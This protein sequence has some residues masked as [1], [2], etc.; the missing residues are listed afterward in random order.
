[1]RLKALAG[2]LGLGLFAAIT[3]RLFVW[4]ATDPPRRADA[5]LVFA[6]G[7]GERLREGTRR[8][9][10]G[11]APVLVV[12]DGGVPG[13]RFARAC[14]QQL[15]IRVVCVTPRESSTRAEARVFAELAEREG[16]RSV[17]MVTSSY[18]VRRASL[19]LGRCYR[20]K[21]FTVAARPPR[22]GVDLAGRAL[23]E[24]AGLAAALTVQRGC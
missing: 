16:W 22:T 7:R 9:Q 3:A 21:V 5:V 18:H 8:V 4:P 13:S 24:W 11:V 19:L 10:E 15:G 14:R 20:G 6:G 23:R 1:M 2:L 12:S 17:A